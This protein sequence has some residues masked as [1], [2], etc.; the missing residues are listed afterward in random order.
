VAGGVSPLSWV[1]FGFGVERVIG[2]VMGVEV[3]F[4]RLEIRHASCDESVSVSG[5]T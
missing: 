5:A 2:Q 4:D 1:F 3:G